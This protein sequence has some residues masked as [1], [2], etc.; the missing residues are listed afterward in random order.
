MI[1]YDPD[2]APHSKDQPNHKEKDNT[3]ENS[4]KQFDVCANAAMLQN[5]NPN[6]WIP[7]GSYILNSFQCIP[8]PHDFSMMIR[9]IQDH[10]ESP[11]G[12]RFRAISSN[13][14]VQSIRRF[15]PRSQLRTA[16]SSSEKLNNLSSSSGSLVV[17]RWRAQ[18]FLVGR[19]LTSLT[20][21][22]Q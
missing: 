13:S 21:K 14:A 22:R 3:T 10:A 12:R 7:C 1:P 6:P 18:P 17:V 15:I 20:P 2:L 19:S 16:S 5:Q 9:I 11:S 8:K 4:K